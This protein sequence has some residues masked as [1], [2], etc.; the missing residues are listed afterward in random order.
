MEDVKVG[1]ICG[2]WRRIGAFVIDG[3]VLGVFGI[4][5]GLFFKDAFVQMGG[6]GRLVGFVV[7]I[8][9]F[10]VMNSFVCHGQTVGKRLLKI[11]VVDSANASISIPRSLL[12][13]SFLAIPFSLNGAQFGDDAV[14]SL[15]IYPLT[16]IVFGGLI[17]IVY[18][19]VFNG[20]SRQSVHDLVAGTYVVNADSA[21][22]VLAPVWRPHLVIVS[23]LVIAVTLVPLYTSGLVESAPFKGLLE[24]QRVIVQNPDVTYAGV[25]EGSTTFT[26]G[27]ASPRT[28]TYVTAEALLRKDDTANKALARALA[29]NIV[30]TYPESLNK[31]VI[32]VTLVYGYDIGIASNWSRY[33]HPFDPSA[34]K[35]TE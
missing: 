14:L 13:Y 25:S 9:Y 15:W 16:F 28:T 33:S 34:L 8:A 31:D 1:W 24:T 21:P 5:L 17:S 4:L 2:F 30:T 20:T 35:K 3:L 11:R 32:Q 22:E 29:E 10:G 7:S 23:G 27:D 26:S 18:L 12:R 19:Y 6:W